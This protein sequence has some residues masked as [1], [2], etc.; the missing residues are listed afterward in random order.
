M[1]VCTAF[2]DL[3]E[4]FVGSD[5]EDG[6]LERLRKVKKQLEEQTEDK[7]K[8]VNDVKKLVFNLKEKFDDNRENDKRYTDWETQPA[9][10]A[11]SQPASQPASQLVVDF[12][13]FHF[14]FYIVNEIFSNGRKRRIKQRQ[15]KQARRKTPSSNRKINLRRSRSGNKILDSIRYIFGIY[16][17]TSPK[18]LLY[19]NLLIKLAMPIP[20]A[21]INANIRCWNIPWYSLMV[22]IRACSLFIFVICRK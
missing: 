1:K 18:Y 11:A 5:D 12:Y 4:S 9:R 20:T 7:S 8:I 17:L 15:I 3:R 10:Q 14:L 13:L 2:Q 22:L 6:V 21:T 19:K 16:S